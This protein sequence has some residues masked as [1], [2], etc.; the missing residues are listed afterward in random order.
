M[1][2]FPDFMKVQANH[3]ESS[4]QNTKDIDGYYY[5][6]NNGHQMAFWTCYE[7]RV[8]AEHCHDFDEYMVCLSGRYW[9]TVNGEETVLNP[10]DEL[11]IPKG[12]VQ[13]GRCI[14]GTRTIHAFGGQRI[15]QFFCGQRKA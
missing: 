9:A 1:K 4:Q 5:T 11:F 13:S 3:I 6:A 7:D 8:S 2:D 14:A 10:G 15:K 12:A